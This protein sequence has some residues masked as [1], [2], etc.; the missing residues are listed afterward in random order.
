[1]RGEPTGPCVSLVWR[2]RLALPSIFGVQARDAEDTPSLCARRDLET[3]VWRG[4]GR[5]AQRITVQSQKMGS[6]VLDERVDGKEVVNRNLQ[7]WY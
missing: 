3:V 7:T 5:G 4:Q 6:K 2:D 1:M